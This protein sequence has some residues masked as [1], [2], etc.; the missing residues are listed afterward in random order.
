MINSAQSGTAVPALRCAPCGLH[1]CPIAERPDEAVVQGLPARRLC[2]AVPRRWLRLAGCFRLDFTS[3]AP[4]SALQY[5]VYARSAG[6]REKIVWA[7]T[8]VTNGRLSSIRS[9]QRRDDIVVA[10]RSRDI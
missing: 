7:A 6:C 4:D 2:F 9:G 3:R 5:F 10:C 8:G 1:G